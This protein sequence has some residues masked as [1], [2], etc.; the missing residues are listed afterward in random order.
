MIY[1]DIDTID[2][3]IL[4]LRSEEEYTLDIN[5]IFSIVARLI[6]R[7]SCSSWKELTIVNIC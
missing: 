5:D 2:N 7:L 3:L 6:S 4:Y 1:L